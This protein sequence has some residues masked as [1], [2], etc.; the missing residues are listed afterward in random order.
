[1]GPVKVARFCWRSHKFSIFGRYV[2]IALRRQVLD[3]NV[4]LGEEQTFH[5]TELLE[6]GGPSDRSNQGGRSRGNSNRLGLVL[7]GQIRQFY[8]AH[9]NPLTYGPV[10]NLWSS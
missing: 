5:V 2:Y 6:Q 8:Y 10:C 7:F 4:I 9:D 1:M 3:F